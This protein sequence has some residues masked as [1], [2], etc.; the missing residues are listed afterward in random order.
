MNI[1]N[2]YSQ[3]LHHQPTNN[4]QMIPCRNRYTLIAWFFLLLAMTHLVNLYFFLIHSKL[5]DIID[6]AIQ[7]GAD[8]TEGID[9]DIFALAHLRDGEVA[10]ARRFRRILPK[11]VLVDQK[12]LQFL[13]VFVR[14]LPVFCFYALRP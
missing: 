4:H 12:F 7:Y 11:H 2:M 10:N 8:L 6:L 13:C 3:G 9:G 1:Q 5:Y 14:R